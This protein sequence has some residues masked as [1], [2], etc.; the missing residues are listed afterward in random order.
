VSLSIFENAVVTEH[1]DVILPIVPFTETSGSYVNATGEWQRFQG[2]ATPV[3]EARPAWKVLRVLGNLFD[4]EGFDYESSDAVHDEIRALV[5]VNQP[6]EM[7]ALSLP[8]ALPAIAAKQA[9]RLGSIPLYAIDSLVRRAKVLQETQPI[10]EGEVATVA[11]HPAFAAT[12]GVME[13]GEVLIKQAQAQ[14][15][16]PVKFDDRLAQRSALIAGGIAATAGLAD[17]YGAVVIE[18]SDR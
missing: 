1:A 15:R 14:V 16:L 6:G 17:L 3:G 5:H 10:L 2:V 9:S 12:L 11:L 18:K 8:A 7:A 4:L 13:G